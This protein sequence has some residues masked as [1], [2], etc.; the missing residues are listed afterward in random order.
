MSIF[1]RKQK[2]PNEIRAKNR[3]YYQVACLYHG[4]AGCRCADGNAKRREAL[5]DPNQGP[6]GASFGRHD[7]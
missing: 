1:T 7:V 6:Y 4:N 3:R 5:D 2:D